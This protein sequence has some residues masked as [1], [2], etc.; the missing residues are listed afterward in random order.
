MEPMEQERRAE[1]EERRLVA[2]VRDSNDAIRVQ[3]FDG[4]V[5]AWN[6]GAERMYGWSEAEALGMNI[7]DR[8]PEARRAEASTL[9]K[10]LA[11]GEAVESFETQR[12]T[13]DGRT[14]DVWLTA[15]VLVDS[16]GRP[17]AIATSERDVTAR[18]RMEE[19]LREASKVLR[20][21]IVERKRAEEALFKEKE[22]AQ[23]TLHSIGDAVITTD[24]NEDMRPVHD[25]MPVVLT[26]VG[27]RAWLRDADKGALD[28]LLADAQ[29]RRFNVQRVSTFVNNSR[30]D[31]PECMQP[32][33]A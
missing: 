26:S 6:R 22:R 32:L 15:T 10:R 29:N 30:N 23:V 33:A 27:V 21:E 20:E 25:R 19:E 7:G 3:T 8:V 24:A 5:T 4:T 28:A 16:E 1:A 18:K 14:L 11:Q 31:G 13:K 2:I 9:A 12:A 17:A